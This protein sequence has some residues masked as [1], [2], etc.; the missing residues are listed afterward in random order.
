MGTQLSPV[1]AAACKGAATA[2]QGI[3]IDALFREPPGALVRHVEQPL[4]DPKQSPRE[5]GIAQLH[6]QSA[7]EMIV[8]STSQPP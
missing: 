5:E 7:R 4:L 3:D 2:P 8:A 6:T 1:G